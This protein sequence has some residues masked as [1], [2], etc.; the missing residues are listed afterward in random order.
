MLT[1]I[2][3]P[4]VAT[5]I[6]GDDADGKELQRVDHQFVVDLHLQRLPPSKAISS[7]EDP[8][9]PSATKNCPCP[10]SS[11]LHGL[12]SHLHHNS[13]HHQHCRILSQPAQI[14]GG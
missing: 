2:C 13:F 9:Q 3:K 1:Q 12:S 7:G 8:S 4:H 5:L 11:F 14:L 6:S 10:S